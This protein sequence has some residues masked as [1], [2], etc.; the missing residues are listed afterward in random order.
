MPNWAQD[1]KT[2]G[3]LWD[4]QEVGRARIC[5]AWRGL[6]DSIFNCCRFPHFQNGNNLFLLICSSTVNCWRQLYIAQYN[7]V[8]SPIRIKTAALISVVNAGFVWH[9]QTLK[10]P[11]KFSKVQGSVLHHQYIWFKT[12]YRQINRYY[13]V[14]VM[15]TYTE[16]FSLKHLSS[17]SSLS[18][19]AFPVQLQTQN[20]VF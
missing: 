17:I 15:Y 16:S 9:A 10:I 6:S 7:R 11:N 12:Y 19:I 14:Y 5:S 1:L 13:K 8:S 2:P 4:R 18:A 20:Q 3:N